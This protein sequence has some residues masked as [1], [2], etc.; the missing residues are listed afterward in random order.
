MKNIYNIAP[1]IAK[2]VTLHTKDQDCNGFKLVSLN[3]IFACSV[4][5]ADAFIGL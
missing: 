5:E 4:K 2:R 3:E 1:V